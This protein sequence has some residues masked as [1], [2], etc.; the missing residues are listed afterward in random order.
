VGDDRVSATDDEW[1]DECVRRLVDEIHEGAEIGRA[2]A[3]RRTPRA[4][5]ADVL[6]NWVDLFEGS[7]AVSLLTEAQRASDSGSVWQHAAEDF[8]TEH[9]EV[10]GY[11]WRG[12]ADS[13]A[14]R[15]LVVWLADGWP[16][17]LLQPSHQQDRGPVLH[18]NR[19]IV[20]AALD[21]LRGIAV[22]LADDRITRPPLALSRVVLDAA[23]HAYYLLEPGVAPD[24]RLS[25]AL[26]EVLGRLGED[27]NAAKRAGD[28][29]ATADAEAEIAGIFTAVGT[30]RKCN[31]NRRHPP[32]LG[33][34]PVTAASMTRLLLEGASL[35]N[36]LSAVVHL[37]EDE[38][39]R[40]MLGLQAGFEGVHRDSYI[41]FWTT[42]AVVGM[43]RVAEALG[44]YAGWDLGAVLE[45]NETLFQVFADAGG[46]LDEF[47]R[48]DVLKHR[49]AHQ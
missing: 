28:S 5:V 6:A 3:A 9:Q 43:A 38:G 12:V 48:A 16:Q 14:E 10:D 29:V 1:S 41:A 8:P 27:Y 34:A 24:D 44:S 13:I 37:K 45:A 17:G 20:E 18:S 32:F 2:I 7:L 33:S 23:A 30:T 21:H 40:M 49:R 19:R 22:L 35:W 47:H 15:D 31:W 11:A 4:T 26:N 25:R 36:E 42:G 46:M 39:W